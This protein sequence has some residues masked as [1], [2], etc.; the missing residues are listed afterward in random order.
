MADRETENADVGPRAEPI[1][2]SS[3][4]AVL[5]ATAQQQEWGKDSRALRPWTPG[6]RSRSRFVAAA[7]WA[8]TG[9]TDWGDDG[10]RRRS[11]SPGRCRFEAAGNTHT[12]GRLFFRE[13]LRRRADEPA[14]NPGRPG[15]ATRGVP[16]LRSV[17]RFFI[18]GLPREPERHSCIA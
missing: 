10:F 14:E 8:R 7:R 5:N 9:L 11:Q 6:L 12:L 17:A 1:W 16:T 18:T 2:R 3:P 15:T 13:I 4:P